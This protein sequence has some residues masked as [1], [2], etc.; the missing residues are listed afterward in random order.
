MQHIDQQINTNY[1]TLD[2]AITQQED[3]KLLLAT[4][5]LNNH[6]I[7][8]WKK[9]I[10]QTKAT[11]NDIQ[12]LKKQALEEIKRDEYI[13]RKLKLSY[14]RQNTD[15]AFPNQVKR[16]HT[17]AQIH[18]EF[19]P[20]DK[21][22]LEKPKIRQQRFS[23]C[24]RIFS[25]RMMGK[26]G[27][28]Q[29]QDGW[30]QIQLYLTKEQIGELFADFKQWDNGDIITAVGFIFRTD[31]GELSLHCEHIEL[32][33]K[34]L[35]PLPDKFHGLKD[36]E[37][38]YRQRYV[39]LLS[40]EESRNVFIT[41]TKIIKAIR[42]F[43]D[44]NDFMEVE[45]PMLHPIPGGATAK[46][47]STHHNALDMELYL[48]I[49]PELYLKRLIVGGFER[50]YEVN[51][52]FRNEGLST[53]HNPEFSMIEFYQAYAD[54]KQLMDLTENLFAL[55]CEQVIGKTIIDY[56]EHTL[57][58][59]KPFQRLTIKEAI[60][61]QHP[62]LAP[63]TLED[64]QQSKTFAKQ[65]GIDCDKENA[66]GKIITEIFEESVEHTLIQP[67]FITEYPIEVSP[68]ARRNDDNP[69]ITDRFELFI[70]GREIANGFSELNDPEDQAER[71]RQQVEALDSGDDE[72]M[73]Y[74]SDYINAL[75]YGMPPT[76]G[77]GI[78][79]DRLVML[80][81]NTASIRDVLLFP[82]MRPPH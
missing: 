52:N 36:I 32:L 60:L 57:D 41:R 50:V 45:T 38:R 15:I 34:S 17:C 54:Y 21:E 43:F 72:A 82:H 37:Q 27:F 53:R 5:S 61:Q 35:N 39:D 8:Q 19:S 28:A 78:G 68:L 76:A 30:G 23:L 66:L 71:F 3:S 80:L 74:D 49:A 18:N 64:L 77:E 75:S 11:K 58:F 22:Q 40:N 42:Q 59:S 56:Q 20:L 70:A 69:S 63:S 29:L 4:V 65:I 62:N 7:H 10:E 81:T 25:K 12:G 9:T 46:P 24:G 55:L 31:T 6:Q 26:A 44:N 51:R 2:F 73:H 33:T 79:I 1:G 67:T 16:T 14:R 13:Q 48:R 47:F